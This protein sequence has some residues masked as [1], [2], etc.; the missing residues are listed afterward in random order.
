VFLSR[1]WLKKIEKDDNGNRVQPRRRRV[2]MHNVKTRHFHNVLAKAGLWRIRFHDL[3]RTHATLLLMHEESPAYVKD[4]LGDSVIKM[5]EA[6]MV[7]GFRAN[8]KAFNRVLGFN[9]AVSQAPR[10]VAAN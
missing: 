1:Y 3:R 2:E 10:A 6:S 8:H 9:S 7:I 4:K 5:T